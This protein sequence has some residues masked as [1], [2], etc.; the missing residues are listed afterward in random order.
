LV[1]F[2]ELDESQLEALG[3][4]QRENAQALLPLVRSV[5]ETQGLLQEALT[6]DPP[7]ETTVGRLVLAARALQQEI[8]MLRQSQLEAAPD[9]LNL[10]PD[11]REKLQLLQTSLRV[12]P[13]AQIA[14]S[15]NLIRGPALGA[16]FAQGDFSP[17]VPI[18]PVGGFPGRTG[19]SGGDREMRG[20]TPAELEMTLEFLR[21]EVD[22]IGQNVDRVSQRLSIRPV[23]R[24]E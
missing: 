13:I 17:A 9:A 18:P 4:M 22:R 1:G 23:P 5:G 10:S 19:D 14:A 11:Q 3:M 7:D 15:L 20:L 2:L 8:G 6:A 24:A 16:L 12:A 21:S